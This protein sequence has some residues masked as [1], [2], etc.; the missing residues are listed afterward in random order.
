MICSIFMFFVLSVQKFWIK[1]WYGLSLDFRKVQ[2]RSSFTN[3][4]S[5][6]PSQ[7]QVSPFSIH[8]FSSR[9]DNSVKLWAC[10]IQII[11]KLYLFSP[12]DPVERTLRKHILIN[13]CDLKGNVWSFLSWPIVNIVVCITTEFSVFLRLLP[14]CISLA[15]PPK[16]EILLLSNDKNHQCFSFGTI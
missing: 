16:K 1:I 2:H 11:I 13:D 3:S 8:L 12:R 9:S 5:L 10:R 7:F 15:Q 4:F 6:L 14:I